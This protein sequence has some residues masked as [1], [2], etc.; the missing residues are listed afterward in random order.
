MSRVLHRLDWEQ[1]SSVRAMGGRRRRAPN[2]RPPV[3]LALVEITVRAA[4]GAATS[5]GADRIAAAAAV[6]REVAQA[7]C[8]AGVDESALAPSQEGAGIVALDIASTYEDGDVEAEMA[9]V[10]QLEG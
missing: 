6:A 8:M 2:A 1:L 4:V 9:S 5:S 10:A 7:V 3:L